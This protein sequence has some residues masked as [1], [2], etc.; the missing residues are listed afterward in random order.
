MAA[1]ISQPKTPQI[2]TSNTDTKIPT[3]HENLK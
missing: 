1:L 3:T 2:L